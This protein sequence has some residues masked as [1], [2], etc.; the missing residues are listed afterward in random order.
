LNEQPKNNDKDDARAGESAP[1]LEPAPPRLSDTE[2]KL[3]AQ[4]AAV[5]GGLAPDDYATAWWDWYLNLAAHPDRQAELAQSAYEK[6]L[7]SWQFLARAAA[8]EPLAPGHQNLGFAGAA[9]NVWPFN[10]YARAYANWASWWQQALEPAPGKK[11]DPALSRANFAGRML[12]EAA[13]P[14]NF[15]TT[16]PE[17]LQ[18]T[19]AESGRNLIRGFE[20]WLEDAKRAVEGG[21]APGTEDFEVGKQVAV[22]PG[23]VVFRNRLIELL[24][25]SPQ[26]P[27]VYA[28]PVLITPAWIMK[29]YILDLSPRNSLVRYLVEKGHTV[30][31]ISW[32]NP[33]TSDR[34]LGMDDYLRLGFFDALAELQRRIPNQKIHAVGYCIGGTLL[35]IAAA[36]LA[37]RHESPLASVSLLAAQTDFSEPGELSVFITPSQIAMLEAMMHK[38]GVLESE[39]MGAAFALLRSR[40]LLWTPAVAQYVR[41]ERPKL[42]D[43]MAW[44]AD[45]TRMP[46]RMHSEYLERLYLKNELAL[47]TFTVNGARIDLTSVTVPMFVVGTETDHVAPWRSVFKARSLTRSTDYTF[48]LTSGGHNAGIVSGPVHPKRRHRL[49]ASTDVSDVPTPEEWLKRAPLHE[50]SWWPSWEAWLS[51]HSSAQQQ[52]ARTVTVEGPAEDAP[53]RYVHG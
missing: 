23:K 47:G 52:P 32:K 35:A 14:A 10:A 42:N 9:W 13:S 29:Y 36:A 51:A 39:R 53:G 41:G 21:R 16:N 50:G 33:D 4:L 31:M 6:T 12:L 2:R 11:S 8:G 44:N 15:L 48:L 5:S 27:T 45:G 37:E 3:R 24:Q 1:E 30:F 18:R 19:A 17:L 20:N 43:L 40:D 25:Y 49:L 28:E 46:W 22:T 7:D 38:A 34:E 26:T